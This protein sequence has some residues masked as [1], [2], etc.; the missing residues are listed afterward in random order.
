MFSTNDIYLAYKKAYFGRKKKS[1]V[2]LYKQNLEYNLINLKNELNSK[3]Y[4]H[5]NYNSFIVED[6]K[7]REIN[8]PKF[9]DHILHHLIHI[10][11]TEIFEKKFIYHS[12]ANRLNKG[13][14]KAVLKLKEETQKYNWY[15]KLDISKYFQNINHEILFNQIKKVTNDD[16][17]LYYTK[18]IIE[19]FN[20]ENKKSIPIGNVISQLFAN[21]YLHDLDFYV[22]HILKSKFKLFY[23]RYV[24]DFVFL[25]KEKE[26]LILIR[27]LALNFLDKKLKLQVPHRK[28]DLNKIETR[29]NFLGYIIYFAKNKFCSRILDKNCCNIIYFAKNKFYSKL[30]IK[31]A[32]IR[33]FKKI[34]K[35]KEKEDSI[36]SL[37]SFKGHCDLTNSN[38]IESLV[39]SILDLSS[40][41]KYKYKKLLNVIYEAGSRKQEAGS[42][43]QEAGSRKDG[44]N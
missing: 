40:N 38:L 29:I 10:K 30:K 35:Y 32:T 34:T 7:K 17:I 11:L 31:N 20:Y 24:D 28:Q 43:K 19:S 12:Y 18:L 1:D 15:L 25:T 39:T 23:I 42:R 5:S 37:M 26:D 6:S 33:R 9:E 8:S 2:I 3:I 36:H 13:S 27:S 14:H 4:I 21:I 41:E 44:K 16:Y 22:E